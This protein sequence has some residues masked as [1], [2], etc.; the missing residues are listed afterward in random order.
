MRR[1]ITQNRSIILIL[2][3][4]KVWIL[5]FKK[6]KMQRK[7]KLFGN[8][9]FIIFPLLKEDQNNSYNKQKL[10]IDPYLL[11]YQKIF[12]LKKRLILWKIFLNSLMEKEIENSMWNILKESVKLK[13]I[14]SWLLIFDILELINVSKPLLLQI[15]EISFKLSQA[16]SP[17]KQGVNKS[18]RYSNLK[19]WRK[20]ENSMFSSFK[21][22]YQ[23]TAEHNANIWIKNWLKHLVYLLRARNQSLFKSEKPTISP[24]I[25]PRQC[26][27]AMP[28]RK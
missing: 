27:S 10:I 8:L 24:L 25:Q 18:M 13:N 7:R 11:D 2:T 23:Q 9:M 5:V 22:E 1:L 14:P 6:M 15:R 16:D 28:D 17:E 21:D 4:L 26:N 12:D 20:V 19:S 3:S